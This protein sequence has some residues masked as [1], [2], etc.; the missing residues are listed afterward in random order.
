MARYIVERH[1]RAR[2]LRARR[3]RAMYVMIFIELDLIVT[4]DKSDFNNHLVKYCALQAR[5][6]LRH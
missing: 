1:V 5:P 2:H 3:T 4:G 6:R